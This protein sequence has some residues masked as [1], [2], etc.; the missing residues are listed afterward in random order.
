MEFSSADGNI[1]SKL[2]RISIQKPRGAASTLAAISRG[3]RPLEIAA[4]VLAAPLGFFGWI[5][6]LA[7][8]EYLAIRFAKLHILPHF[9]LAGVPRV[10][11]SDVK[12]DE[13]GGNAV[14][15]VLLR[16]DLSYGWVCNKLGHLQDQG[17]HVRDIPSLLHI[18][19]HLK[20]SP[21]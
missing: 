5:S 18:S 19:Y 21:T 6:S 10:R 12:T 4:R 16:R 9:T 11:A 13:P 2:E 14:A 3:L 17:L 1:H 20:E 8:R 15:R 7:F